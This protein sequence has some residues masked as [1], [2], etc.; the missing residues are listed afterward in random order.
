MDKVQLP[1]SDVK[2]TPITFG[3]WAIGG[4]FWGGAEENESIKAIEAAIANGMTTIDTAPVYGFGQSEEF[5]GK[6]IKGK[7]SKVE[8]LTKFGLVWDRKSGHIHYEKT[9]D[10]EGNPVSLYRL[11]S[12][13]NVIKECEDCLQRL[14]TDYID[15]F[16]Q[17]WPDSSTPLEETMEALEIL[18]DQGK[19]RAG[20]VS[21]YSANEM[22]KAEKYFKL[23]SNQVP[24]SM[25]N[26]DIEDEV[27]PHCIANNKAII[28]YSPLQRGVLTG[29]ITADYKFSE[30]DHRPTTPFFKEP[31]L[32]R[33]NALLDKI[34]PI[35]ESKQ[36]TLAQLVLNWTMRQPGI[37]CVLA[38]ARNEKQV[39]ENLKAAELMVSD[40]EFASIRKKLDQL[41]LEV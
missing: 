37:T 19:I 6:A 23:S 17:H 38:G 24:Y 29:K 27:V 22:K 12:K 11:G 8:L 34:K 4:W 35:A 32:S 21:N 30:G 40:D 18:K 25:V 13:K 2:I 36:A 1:S 39:L 5:V 26:R 3:A 28:A 15:L 33:I 31:N 20:G 41:T 10:N 16:Q 14:G 7:R 9:V